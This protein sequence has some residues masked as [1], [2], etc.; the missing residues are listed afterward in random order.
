ML[1]FPRFGCP[2]RKISPKFHG[3]NGVKNRKF[4][5]NFTLLGRGAENFCPFP[6]KPQQTTAGKSRAY[7]KEPFATL[8]ILCH[9]GPLVLRELTATFGPPSHP[10]LVTRP[11]FPPYRE[12]GVAIPL[13]HCVLCGIAD[14]RCYN[15][16]SFRKSGLSQ[17][18]W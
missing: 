1:L 6:E 18:A 12:T 13:S 16:T 7:R 5:A 8:D 17:E 11:K 15:P 3:K 4:H 2:K 14:Y 10:P 9:L